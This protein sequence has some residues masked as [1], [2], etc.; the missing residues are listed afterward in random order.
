MLDPSRASADVGDAMRENDYGF[1][2]APH[3]P[4]SS[5]AKDLCPH[6]SEIP[7]CGGFVAACAPKPA[8]TTTA[9]TTATSSPPS[10]RS[11]PSL[12]PIAVPGGLGMAAQVF[13]WLLVAALVIAVLVP[14]VRALARMRRDKALADPVRDKPAVEQELP[15][16]ELVPTTS[17]EDAI[18]RRA[19]EH[20][21]RGEYGVALQLY[22]AASLRALD[23]RGAVRVARD[24]TNGEYVRSCSDANAKPALRDIV[25]EVDRVQFGRENPTM[26]AVSRAAQRATAIVRAM[27]VMMLSLVVAAL[28][29]GCGGGGGAG[30]SKPGDD[31]A[32]S[33]LFREVLRRQGVEVKS[34]GGSLATLPSPKPGARDPA[35]IVDVQTTELD[36]DARTHLGDWVEEGGVLVIAGEP[37]RWPSEFGVT[38]AFTSGAHTVTARRLLARGSTTGSGEE[39]E[40]AT[41]GAIY[42][43]ALEHG[44]LASGDALG[45]SAVTD[46]LAW[47]PDEMTYAAVVPRGKGW[48]VGIA[49]D[50]LFTNAGLSRPGNAA[51]LVAILAATDRLAFR[52]A[53]PDDGMSPPSTPIAALARAGL[54]LGMLHGVAAMLVLFFAV[55]VRMARPKPA[56]PP[57]RRAFAEHVEAVGALYARTRNAPHALAA[58]A[59]FADER[60][61]TRMP[62]GTGDVPAFLAS[63]AR[64]PLDACQ[65]VWTRAVAAK[66]GAPPLGD[67]LA[68]LKELSAMYA[69]AMAQD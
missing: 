7:G 45:W 16:A 28:A 29:L 8:P 57:A 34:L 58:Y 14:I 37:S 10:T 59:R 40:S 46:R 5:R 3:E 26:D 67:E 4:L 39:E 49:N 66:A 64:M 24:R 69:A 36:D 61:R 22:L 60:L 52:I 35:V 54:G 65:R 6:A 21:R 20:A 1:C 25:R 47:Y 48:V 31:P 2:K 19:E 32:G 13:V 55:G 51:V 11:G 12:H 56:P 38:R 50:E 63:R 23:K 33:E 68:V 62:R 27:P 30:A 9:T 44:A 15:M 17:D 43:S 53:E 41:G 18:L 42:A